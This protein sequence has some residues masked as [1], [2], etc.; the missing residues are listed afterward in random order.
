MNSGKKPDQFWINLKLSQKIKSF[1]REFIYIE[2]CPI[3]TTLILDSKYYILYY[4]IIY[5]RA[6]LYYAILSIRNT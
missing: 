1:S 2:L 3:Y 5:C 4:N 6:L